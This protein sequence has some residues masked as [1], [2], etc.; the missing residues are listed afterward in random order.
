VTHLNI[1]DAFNH[2]VEGFVPTDRNEHTVL[3]E[4]RLFGAAGCGE[5]VVLGEAF[6]AELAAVDRVV[7]VAADGDGLV[8]AHAEEH[9][10]TDRAVAA[11]GLDPLFRNA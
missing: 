9:A 4:Q 5:D 3:A 2:R 7:R 8:V 11:R 6:G 10:A 1:A